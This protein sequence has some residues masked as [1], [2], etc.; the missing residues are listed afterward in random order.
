MNLL[1]EKRKS[2]R[3]SLSTLSNNRA[4]NRPKYGINYRMQTQP[5]PPS[6]LDHRTQLLAFHNRQR[7][8]NHTLGQARQSQGW[9]AS[10]KQSLS[11]PNPYKSEWD[12]G[13]EFIELS[14]TGSTSLEEDRARRNKA[15]SERLQQQQKKELENKKPKEEQKKPQ[16]VEF[17]DIFKDFN[18]EIPGYNVPAVNQQDTKQKITNSGQNNKLDHLIKDD[19]DLDKFLSDD[20]Q[21]KQFLDSAKHL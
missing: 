11:K 12:D 14:H 2:R 7:V 19:F 10:S 15:I 13:D 17:N 8:P 1:Q 6:Q 20:Q 3:A 5:E 16:V 18:L 9:P 4:G 21:V